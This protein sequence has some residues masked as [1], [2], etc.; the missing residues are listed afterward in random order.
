MNSR[1]HCSRAPTII[2]EIYFSYDGKN[3]DHY[4]FNLK[5]QKLQTHLEMWSCRRLTLFGKVS[6]IKGLGLS[7]ILYSASN[8]T[9]PKDIAK[10][11]KG[12]LFSFLCNKKRDKIKRESLYQDY[13]N[14]GIR[15][16]NVDLMI[17]T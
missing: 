2:L 7:Q 4:N 8:I 1:G 16:P 12:K 3:D 9:V 14:G 6:T 10:T 17:N 15:M 11:V 5:V 13:D